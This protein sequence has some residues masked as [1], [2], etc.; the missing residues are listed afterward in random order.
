MIP[1]LQLSDFIELSKKNVL[2]E[3]K[4][5]GSFFLS[6]G[7]GLQILRSGGFLENI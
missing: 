1:G 2:N 7:A 5:R 6:L 3:V 4:T